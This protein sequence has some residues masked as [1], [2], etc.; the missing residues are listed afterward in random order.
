M[1]LGRGIF[2]F[3]TNIRAQLAFE[4]IAIVGFGFTFDAVSQVEHLL[5]LRHLPHDLIKTGGL[6]AD[7]RVLN[8]LAKQKNLKDIGPLSS[9]ARRP[10]R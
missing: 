1:R 4:D 7:G 8:C 6:L 10:C 2:V 5:F 9:E 3:T